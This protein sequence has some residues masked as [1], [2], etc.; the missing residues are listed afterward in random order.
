MTLFL[1][2]GPGE[3]YHGQRVGNVIGWNENNLNE[4]VLHGGTIVDS[5]FISSLCIFRRLTHV[6]VDG[7][8]SRE[9][10]CTFLLTDD[11]VTKLADTLPD[12]K[13]LRLGPPCVDDRC[14]PQPSHFL[15]SPRAVQN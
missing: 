6:F 11:D 15:F 10:G 4:V 13:N 8:C 5:A 9:G 3:R 12:I 1:G 14:H 2:S 7:S